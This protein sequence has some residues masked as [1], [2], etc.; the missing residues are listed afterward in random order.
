MWQARKS[1]DQLLDAQRTE[2][3]ADL[4]GG[5]TG[6]FVTSRPGQLEDLG[7]GLQRLNIILKASLLPIFPKRHPSLHD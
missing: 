5:S 2:R 7:D 4:S 3:L 6:D 1:A